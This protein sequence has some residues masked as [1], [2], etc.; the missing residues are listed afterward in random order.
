MFVF[1]KKKRFVKKEYVLEDDLEKL[2][3]ILKSKGKRAAQKDLRKDLGLSEAKVSLMITDLES[4]GMVKKIK[5]GRGN[6]II[7]VEN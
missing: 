7:L 5:K 2:V 1:M 6:I 4:R 3:N